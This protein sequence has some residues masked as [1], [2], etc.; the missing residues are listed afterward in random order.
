MAE[1]HAFAKLQMHSD[2]TFE[3]LA[4]ITT[5]I[6]KLMRDFEKKSLF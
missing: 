1:W 6:G 3:H 2:S 5:K 4:V